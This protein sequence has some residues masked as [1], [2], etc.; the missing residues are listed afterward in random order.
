MKHLY[1]AAALIENAGLG[2]TGTD[3]FIGTIPEDVHVGIML[4]DPLYGAEIDDGME[5]FFDHEFQVIVRHPRSEEGYALA[6]AVSKALNVRRQTI[7]NL[8]ILRM[9]PQTLPVTYPKG[10]ADKV[11]TSVRIQVA[12]GEPS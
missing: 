11:E 4:K 2:Q 1:I 6:R 7:D 8:Y 12:F 10:D 5:G 9:S 3:L